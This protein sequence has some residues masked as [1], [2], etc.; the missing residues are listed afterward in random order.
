MSRK[1][2]S[3]QAKAS[4]LVNKI[5]HIIFNDASRL[6]HIF[7][8]FSIKIIDIAT[9]R[10]GILVSIGGSEKVRLSPEFFFSNWERFKSVHN[11]RFRFVLKNLRK[12]D[13]SINVGLILCH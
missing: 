6:R 9:R 5:S 11:P 7:K 8:P 13:V 1:I 3:F 2:L 10:R 4:G 12:N